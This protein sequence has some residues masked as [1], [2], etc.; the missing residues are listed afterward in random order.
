MD[1]TNDSTITTPCHTGSARG[2]PSSPSGSLQPATTAHQRIAQQRERQ[3]FTSCVR[4]RTAPE[5]ISSRISGRISSRAAPSGT[6]SSSILFCQSPACQSLSCQSL[7][8]QSS[9]CQCR[10]TN[11]APEVLPPRFCP[12]AAAC[13]FR[14]A[15]LKLTARLE[16]NLS[17]WSLEPCQTAPEPDGFG[18][19]CRKH[20]CCGAVAGS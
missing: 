18:S 16:G 13:A 1:E 19:D 3:A 2:C 8:C 6:Q 11:S 10:I 7:S 20:P 5:L 14:D 12:T 9:S 4:A 17:W 15:N